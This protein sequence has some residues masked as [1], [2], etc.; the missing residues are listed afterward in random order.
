MN[1]KV[2]VN[3][4]YS[5]TLKAVSEVFNLISYERKEGR[6]KIC[7]SDGV[8]HLDSPKPGQTI[9]SLCEKHENSA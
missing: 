6:Y 8:I 2:Y 4:E 1:M 3:G 5:Y 9:D 7:L